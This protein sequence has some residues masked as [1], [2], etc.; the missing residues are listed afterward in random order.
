MAAPETT[1]LTTVAALSFTSAGYTR[2]AVFGVTVA[3][4]TPTEGQLWPR[5]SSPINT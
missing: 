4:P 2:S 3:P 1:D 5:G